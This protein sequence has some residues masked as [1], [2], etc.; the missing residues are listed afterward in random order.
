[1][2][3]A[4]FTVSS[5]ALTDRENFPPFQTCFYRLSAV[6]TAESTRK[7]SGRVTR[8][9]DWDRCLESQ[10]CHLEQGWAK[11]QLSDM[12]LS[13]NK[14][15]YF[16]LQLPSANMAGTD[17]PRMDKRLKSEA[18]H[19]WFLVLFLLP[20][21]FAFTSIFAGKGLT[22]QQSEVIGSRTPWASLLYLSE[23]PK[24]NRN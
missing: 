8:G 23:L 9:W 16:R 14:S 18:L 3:S 21:I 19:C 7:V 24:T 13:C 1:M 20:K 5:A 2:V 11:N 12:R 17:P 10:A 4:N 6:Q 22:L 15:Q